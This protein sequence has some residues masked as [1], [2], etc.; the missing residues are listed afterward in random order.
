MA[1]EK[2]YSDGTGESLSEIF[3]RANNE[4]EHAIKSEWKE[5][6]RSLIDIDE[7]YMFLKEMEGWTPDGIIDITL[8]D[9]TQGGYSS[10]QHSG[11]MEMK[12]GC[13]I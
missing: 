3:E 8:T 6:L 4:E 7:L 9:E 11:L 2:T 5:K 13:F 12:P 10:Y 1:K